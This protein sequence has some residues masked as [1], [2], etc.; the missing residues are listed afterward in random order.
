MS[1]AVLDHSSTPR[2]LVGRLHQAI[3]AKEGVKIEREIR[4]SR[5]S[6]SRIISACSRNFWHDRYRGNR[7][8]QFDNIYK[9]EVIVI[10]TNKPMLRLENPDVVSARK[11]KNISQLRMNSEAAR[12]RKP[13]L[14]RHNA[15]E[16][17]ERLSS[18]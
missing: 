6:P 17:S 9:L 14:V 3:E 12:E 16:K 18:C 15:I 7:S 1:F 8:D 2:R 13:V 5:Q 10:P 11:K 4:R